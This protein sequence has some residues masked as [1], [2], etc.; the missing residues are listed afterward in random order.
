M[1]VKK[2][3]GQ[4]GQTVV[5]FMTDGCTDRED[6]QAAS[7]A[8]REIHQE[9]SGNVITFGVPLG[10]C[11]HVPSIERIVKEGNGG[12]LDKQM[13]DATVGFVLPATEIQLLT[14]MFD[15]ILVHLDSMEQDFI[16]KLKWLD[17]EEEK[18]KEKAEREIEEMERLFD[19][20]AAFQEARL[21]NLASSTAG[22]VAADEAL[23]KEL[24]ILQD[25]EASVK[26]K[27]VKI[28][29]RKRDMNTILKGCERQVDAAT[30]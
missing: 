11:P 26:T 2:G 23:Q 7:I 30:K 12:I 19:K 4:V 25:E 1:G 13:G 9:C 3:K 28:D 27:R 5:V 6:V 17:Q 15:T 16:R 18:L 14:S 22:D 10:S 20:E 21:K 24:K 29:E 8:A